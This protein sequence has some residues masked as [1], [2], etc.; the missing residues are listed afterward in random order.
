[1]HA[2]LQAKPAGVLCFVWRLYPKADLREGQWE[3]LLPQ[4]WPPG[5]L[6]GMPLAQPSL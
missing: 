5:L 3:V 4:G 2:V 6:D 1:M